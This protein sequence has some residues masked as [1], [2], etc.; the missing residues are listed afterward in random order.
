[1]NAQSD[2]ALPRTVIAVAAVAAL[3][4]LIPIA[5]LASR[6]EWAALPD[7][8]ASPAVREALW[9]SLRTSTCAAIA[10]VL[11][12]VPLGLALTRLTGPAR[13]VA[14]AFLLAP[15]VLPPVVSGL[16]LLYALGR[17]GLIGPALEAFGVTLSFTTAAVIIAQ[18]FVALP[19]MVA[20][21]EAAVI[22]NGPRV[23][24]VAASFG[25]SRWR[26]LRDV[27]LPAIAP[28]IATGAV[29]A[30]ARSLGE[31]GATITFAGSA[32]GVTR[33]AP[34]LIYLARE[35]DPQAA[36]ALGLVLLAV[37]VLI[38]AAALGPAR[39]ARR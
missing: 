11:L 35:S 1:M 14:R 9:L 6:M 7:Q 36:V 13:A 33:T 18:T 28:G 21:V 19:F 17:R 32:E 10:C 25:A 15:L 26:V 29:L 39:S 22:S 34:L 4:A 31:F 27:T 23:G 38:V 37:A 2:V 5:G 8:L 20:A 24:L 16:G 12:G 3:C 30:F